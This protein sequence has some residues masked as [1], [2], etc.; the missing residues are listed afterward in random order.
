MGLVT[1]TSY[2]VLFEVQAKHFEL[3][4][5]PPNILAINFF[6]ALLLILHTIFYFL[7]LLIIQKIFLSNIVLPFTALFTIS[8]LFFGLAAGN[9]S[10]CIGCKQK[11]SF[12]FTIF[13]LI[14]ILGIAALYYSIYYVTPKTLIKVV[15]FSLIVLSILSYLISVKLTKKELI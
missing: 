11:N 15:V 6:S 8:S 3:P 7:I 4:K 5:T 2:L 14:A 1:C 12:K 10:F 9:F 13:S